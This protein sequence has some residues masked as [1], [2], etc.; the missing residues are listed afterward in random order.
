MVKRRRKMLTNLGDFRTDVSSRENDIYSI[1]MD[2]TV[3]KKEGLESLKHDDAK[4][5][6]KKNTRSKLVK[7]LAE[8]KRRRIDGPSSPHRSSISIGSRKRPRLFQKFL[9]IKS[10]DSKA[11][12]PTGPCNS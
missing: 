4:E 2:E 9:F 1:K 11:G 12:Y 6:D 5:K 3:M 7:D 10:A 8:R